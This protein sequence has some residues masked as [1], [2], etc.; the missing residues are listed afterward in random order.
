MIE[1]LNGNQILRIVK[2]AIPLWRYSD[3]IKKEALPDILGP[4]GDA[5]IWMANAKTPEVGHWTCVKMEERAKRVTFFS[6]YGG[7]PDE[8]KN[9]KMTEE[10][11]IRTNQL[12][13]WLLHQLQ[14]LRRMGYSIHYNDAKYQVTGDRSMSCGAWVAHYL[15][16]PASVESFNAYVD[17]MCRLYR[18][19]YH[20]YIADWLLR[21]KYNE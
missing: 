8:E 15:T 1:P 5:I 9:M 21:Q 7:K 6:S 2:R 3:I 17:H 10:E 4:H 14:L 11:L 20:E 16:F 19:N 18:T 12:P 13:N